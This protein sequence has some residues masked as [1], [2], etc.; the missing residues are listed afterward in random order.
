MQI[1]KSIALIFAITL[2]G[3]G[4]N[5]QLEHINVSQIPQDEIS[6]AFNVK[7]YEGGAAHPTVVQFIAN[8]DATSCKNLMWDA[9]PT[10]GDALTQLRLKALR[11]GATAIIEVH[12]D[13]QGTDAFGTNCWK[14]ITASGTAVV[15]QRLP[16][17]SH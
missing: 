6:K 8:L 9:P 5:R 15:L 2:A 7:V 12:F 17:D 14:S 10:K 13:T 3:C 16:A 1:K 4:P 11:L